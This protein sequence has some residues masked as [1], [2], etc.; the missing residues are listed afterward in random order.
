MRAHIDWIKRRDTHTRNAIDYANAIDFPIV[1]L[2]IYY[3][4]MAAHMQ[5]PCHY[6]IEVNDVKPITRKQALKL[7]ALKVLYMPDGVA[8]VLLV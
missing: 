1:L 4:E 2:V 8:E 3:S 5:M 6:L 7:H